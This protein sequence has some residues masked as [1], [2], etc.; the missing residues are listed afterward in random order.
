MQHLNLAHMTRCARR[1]SLLLLLQEREPSGHDQ[2][3]PLAAALRQ[4]SGGAEARPASQAP[5]AERPSE[6]EASK[7]H[8]LTN[9]MSKDD[10]LF[11]A[12]IDIMRRMDH[13]SIVRYIGCG[14]LDEGGETYMAI[15]RTRLLFTCL[16]A[17]N[18]TCANSMSLDSF[19]ANVAWLQ[20]ALARCEVVL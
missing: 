11:L 9:N 14:V 13:P 17:L 16:D 18:V 3:L 4:M 6:A 15:V 2:P 20:C 5:P 19:E 10:K 7:I 1:L 12:E 8:A